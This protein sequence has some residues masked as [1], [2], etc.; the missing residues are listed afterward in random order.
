MPCARVRRDRRR[1]S[2]GCEFVAGTGGALETPRSVFFLAS[3]TKAIVATAVMRYV[4]EGRLDLHAP[5]SRYLPELAGSAPRGVSAWH[6]LTHTSG[7][8][9][10]PIDSLRRER[11]TYGRTLRVRAASSARRPSRAP[12]YAYNSVAFILLAEAMARL[13]RAPPSPRRWRCA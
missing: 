7:L 1:R 2:L 11:P 4:D 6:V 8:P 13:S 3:I 9:D 5:L 12:R 10:M